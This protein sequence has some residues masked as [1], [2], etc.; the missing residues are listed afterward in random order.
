[1][2]RL[3]AVAAIVVSFTACDTELTSIQP[4]RADTTVVTRVDT[5]F[6]ERVVEVEDL[7]ARR[8]LEWIER[9]A[10]DPKRVGERF[11][12]D[13]CAAAREGLRG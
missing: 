11:M 7:K 2:K 6:V 3:A 13:V 12:A 5:V 9:F 10:C 8:A 1:M 4:V